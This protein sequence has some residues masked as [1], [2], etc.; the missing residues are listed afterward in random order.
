MTMK[1]IDDEDKGKVKREKMGR[2]RSALLN[3]KAKAICLSKILVILQR[4]KPPGIRQSL[5]VISASYIFNEQFHGR[6]NVL[7]SILRDSYCRR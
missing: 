4:R 1:Y 6:N 5:S 7:D 2:Q 3:E